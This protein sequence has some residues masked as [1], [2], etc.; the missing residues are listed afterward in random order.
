MSLNSV[1]KIPSQADDDKRSEYV[2]GADDISP[3][4]LPSAYVWLPVK[5]LCL[6]A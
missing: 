6:S 3:L 4:L 1:K 5:A 2:G